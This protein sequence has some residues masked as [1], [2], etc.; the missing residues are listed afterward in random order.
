MILL[1]LV[2][3]ICILKDACMVTYLYLGCFYLVR[4]LVRRPLLAENILLC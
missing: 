1:I 2:V 3:V 4:I